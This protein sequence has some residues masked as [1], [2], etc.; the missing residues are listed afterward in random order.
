MTISTNRRMKLYA[1]ANELRTKQPDGSTGICIPYGTWHYGKKDGREVTQTFDEASADA[2]ANELAAAVAA[3]GPGTPVYQ[4]HPDVP[5]LAHKYPDKS[6]VGWV[7]AWEKTKDGLRAVVEWLRDPGRGFGWHSPY[8]FGSVSPAG[9]G[10]ANCHV[11]HLESIGL[12][13]NPNIMDF[14]LAN[15]AQ[16][17]N[18][19]DNTMNRDKLI[20]LLGLAPDATDEQIAAA[21][22]KGAEAIK[23]A[24]A[25]EKD[26]AT[27]IEAAQAEAEEARKNEEEAKEAFA[28]ERKARRDLL[29]DQAIAGGNITPAMRAA[30]EKRLDEDFETGRLALANER[31]ALKTRSALGAVTPANAAGAKPDLVALANERMKARPGLSY[32]S[33]F[34]QVMKEHPEVK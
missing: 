31:G 10:C 7:K 33:A 15:E 28:N 6:A 14:R 32:T 30:W 18:Q 21:I 24:D 2:V 3:G 11:E 22:Q 26:A 19:G 23:A 34:A 4:G 8:W 29:L 20:S 12:V 16:P 13:N 25:A 17:Q 5:E 1:L 9:A 27:K